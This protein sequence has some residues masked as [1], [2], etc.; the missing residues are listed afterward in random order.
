[1]WL[2]AIRKF[3]PHSKLHQSGH[4]RASSAQD[5][6]EWILVAAAWL[7]T[8]AGAPPSVPDSRVPGPEP[9][10]H[11]GGRSPG[12]GSSPTRG[13]GRR[14][15]ERADPR[16]W[17]P[18][19]A[20]REG[21]PGRSA[22]P[23]PHR[24]SAPHARPALTSGALLA[25]ADAA[26]A[27]DAAGARF[28]LAESGSPQPHARTPARHALL[29]GASA[30]GPGARSPALSSPP[31]LAT[32]PRGLPPATQSRGSGA[33]RLPP[34]GHVRSSTGCLTALA[35]EQDFIP[36]LTGKEGGLS[37]EGVLASSEGGSPYRCAD[38]ERDDSI[39]R[40]PERIEKRSSSKQ[41]TCFFVMGECKAYLKP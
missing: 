28:L 9:R 22:R 39:I 27:A 5:W 38:N 33:V 40:S 29:P 17:E 31:L 4:P 12:R 7:T 21:C 32:A 25:P 34:L 13:A 19:P 10:E 1:M 2:F 14:S 36:G 23:P 24:V 20:S 11:P 26:D 35:K 37:R 16:A 15:D 3:L 8:R 6:A 30:R 41:A 18:G